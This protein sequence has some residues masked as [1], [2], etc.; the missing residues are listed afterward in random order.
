MHPAPTV[1]CTADNLSLRAARQLY[2]GGDPASDQRPAG[3]V[4]NTPPCYYH[5]QQ[6]AG[7]NQPRAIKKRRRRPRSKSKV[8]RNEGTAKR[9]AGGGAGN[10]V[11]PKTEPRLAALQVADDKV[12]IHSDDYFSKVQLKAKND[13][14]VRDAGAPIARS[15]T[16][17]TNEC[18]ASVGPVRGSARRKTRVGR[19]KKFPRSG[20]EVPKKMMS[21]L[22][23]RELNMQMRLLS[24]VEQGIIDHVLETFAAQVDGKSMRIRDFFN[25]MDSNRDNVLTRSELKEALFNRQ[26]VL[27][28]DQLTHLMA[29][30]DV[31][32]HGYITLGDLHDGLRTFRA[33]RHRTKIHGQST[34]LPRPQ[35]RP[36][37][38]STA[39][40][41]LQSALLAPLTLLSA[42]APV[43]GQRKHQRYTKNAS[44]KRIL[45]Q[46]AGIS[47]LDMTDPE[48]SYLADFLMDAEKKGG[49]PHGGL[50]SNPTDH[51][52]PTDAHQSKALRPLPLVMA[53]LESA[54]SRAPGCI[55]RDGQQTGGTRGPGAA[56]V[57]CSAARVLWI[58]RGLQRVWRQKDRRRKAKT[59]IQ[60]SADEFTDEKLSAAVGLFDVDGQGHIDLEDV[61]TVFRNARVDKCVR[62]RPPAAAIPSLVA[63]GSH[64]ESR[65][66]SAHDFVQDAAASTI[67]DSSEPSGRQRDPNPT[68]KRKRAA[69]RDNA[70]TATTAQLGALL[71]SEL[72]L[73][74]EQRNL[75][76]ECIEED[77][78]VSGAN[79]AGAVRRARGELA[80]RK[81]ERL[82]QQQGMVDGGRCWRSET[83]S[84]VSEL[85]GSTCS[86]ISPPRF[87]RQAGV[88]PT[89]EEG[90][91]APLQHMHQRDVFNQSDASLILELFVKEGG[92]LRNLTGKSAV[93]LWR[94]LKRRGR[95]VHA[96]EHGRSA[97]RRLLQ[98]LGSRDIKPLQWFATLDPTAEISAPSDEGS[99]MERR[100][101]M[102]SIIQGVQALGGTTRN[103]PPG[104]ANTVQTASDDEGATDSL[105]GTLS[106]NDGSY[107]STGKTAGKN[108]KP[109]RWT[110]AQLSALARHLDPCGESSITQEVFQE[111]MCVCR[112]DRGVYPDAAHLAAARRLED[113]MRDVGCRD[114]CGMFRSLAGEGRGGGDLVEYVRQM[115]DF[116]KRSA[117]ELEAAARQE[118]MGRALLERETQEAQR[119]STHKSALCERVSRPEN[120]CALR[121]IQ[122]LDELMSLQGRRLVVELHQADTNR[123]GGVD[124]TE[125]KKV[126]RNMVQPCSLLRFERK[127]RRERQQAAAEISQNAESW[128]EDFMEKMEA[129]DK[130][131]ASNFLDII[132]TALRNRRWQ[133]RDVFRDVDKGKSGALGVNDLLEN[134]HLALG[135]KLDRGEA[136]ALVSMLDTNGDKS[137]QCEELELA[138]RLYRRNGW[139]RHRWSRRKPFHEEFPSLS[140]LFRRTPRA[141]EDGA[142]L[143]QQQ[144]NPAL[145]RD[146][147]VNREDI[148]TALVR[149]R[150]GSSGGAVDGNR[151]RGKLLPAHGP[152]VQRRRVLLRA[153]RKVA[154]C[155]QTAGV[156]TAPALLAT[157]AYF[158]FGPVDEARRKAGRMRA[159]DLW[160]W[161]RLLSAP[162]DDPGGS[163]VGRSFNNNANRTKG[164]H[165]QRR[166]NDV[167]CGRNKSICGFGE[168]GGGRGGAHKTVD[169]M[170][171]GRLLDA[172]ETALLLDA[173]ELRTRVQ[174]ARDAP[175]TGATE[176]GPLVSV[177]AFWDLLVEHVP[178][179][180]DRKLQESLEAEEVERQAQE[181][182]SR[183]SAAALTIQGAARQRQASHARR[184]VRDARAAAEERAKAATTVQ[185]AV[186]RRQASEF[187]WP[188]NTHFLHQ[189]QVRL[190]RIKS[191][192]A[193]TRIQAIERGRIARHHAAAERAA[194]TAAAAK[195]QAEAQAKAE[196]EESARRLAAATEERN[197]A[198]AAVKIQCA[199][200]QRHAR[201]EV[202][203]R[204]RRQQEEAAR[205]AAAV[206]IQSVARGRQARTAAAEELSRRREEAARQAAAIKI[207]S[208]ARGRLARIAAEE[209][210]SQQQEEAAR[211]AAAIKIQSIARGRLT[212]E[213]AKEA[214]RRQQKEEARLAAVVKIQSVVRG[215][216]AREAVK[217]AAE[218]AALDAA[219]AARQAKMAEEAQPGAGGAD[220]GRGGWRKK[221]VVG[222]RCVQGLAGL[223]VQ[224]P[225]NDNAA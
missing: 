123:S 77:G 173:L 206:K 208:A 7:V 20:Q 221:S 32:G 90:I 49:H 179:L 96:H 171:S 172:E 222:A 81:L 170:V 85:T 169:E 13:C 122:K 188:H 150:G 34:R 59:L 197:S 61:M 42:Q 48:I 92:G 183:Q 109:Q 100:V 36:P 26:L 186:R 146:T 15:L 11:V 108:D 27:P 165:G 113:A 44:E 137:I 102:S 159:V 33:A 124:P 25:L 126:M 158:D 223:Q 65:K 82:E 147:K 94:G 133:I 156:R 148:V 145:P 200:R 216:L 28:D 128:K 174:E 17:R 87:R 70:Q 213:A 23:Q 144:R 118:R 161:L 97:A 153:V 29:F 6:E 46:E 83:G 163:A 111:G 9:Y 2:G 127:R 106:S 38:D 142:D 88:A 47:F 66:I 91:L 14:R 189:K 199:T 134:T 51:T 178:G 154:H 130:S 4:A 176:D 45:E 168:G 121:T 185:K 125:L 164:V 138:L 203:R 58:L 78:L 220:Q 160:H 95:G 219:I 12:H 112:V 166:K 37:P 210:L 152:N 129:L 22:S 214:F 175:A 24:P 103:G 201:E 62:G 211:L 110:K 190:D 107:S 132:S 120:A 151:G 52:P 101:A 69:K 63:I 50:P 104:E 198:R 140:C 56:A 76:L 71:F 195:A 75:V 54:A 8:C 167:L 35:P 116:A 80:H 3:S 67:V 182:R 209:E 193:A 202:W 119:I 177:P 192:K 57:P 141:E 136:A 117:R 139:E 115:G 86:I 19:G 30:F 10:H 41:R 207:Q 72:Q 16:P 162:T 135:L 74:A 89:A 205:L 194:R 149:L 5:N 73:D 155:C 40:T 99:S 39:V 31:H 60:E 217:E 191:N 98:L 212:R 196:L 143:Q 84:Q 64:L 225:P 68:P 184:A 114:V 55:D 18:T 79:L 215:W 93:S 53:A 181:V 105:E 157:L 187:A 204:R 43:E 180:W 224:V 218:I 1:G 131:K 21:T